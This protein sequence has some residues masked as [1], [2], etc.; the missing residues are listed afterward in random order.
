MAQTDWGAIT[1][2]QK[3]VWQARTWKQARDQSFWFQTGFMSSGSDDHSKPVD[4]VKDLTQTE[5]GAVCVMHLIPD[6]AGDGVAG[7]NPS[8]ARRRRCPRTTSTSR[9]TS[10]ATPCAAAAP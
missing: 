6:L 9:S 10:C 8:R 2:M 5:R 1:N 4:Y 7:D 3:K